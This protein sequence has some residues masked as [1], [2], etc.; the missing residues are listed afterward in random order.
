LGLYSSV[1]GLTPQLAAG[2][3]HLLMTDEH[4]TTSYP[5]PSVTSD[6]FELP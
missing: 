2:F 4:W 6:F 3:Q 5:V 1:G